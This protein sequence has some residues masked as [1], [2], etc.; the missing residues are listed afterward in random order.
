MKLKKI[1]IFCLWSFCTVCA[2]LV[3]A[4]AWSQQRWQFNEAQQALT[5]GDVATFNKIVE[6]LQDYPIVHYLRYFYLKSYLETV[7]NADVQAFLDKYS[8]SPAGLALRVV[9]LKKL[10]EKQDWPAFLAAY[11]PQKDVSLQCYQ[12]QARIATEQE[13]TGVVE[14][15]KELWLVGKDQP[16]VCDPVFAYFYEQA[17]L[18]DDLRWQR[19]R[20]AMQEGNLKLASQLSKDLPE[21]DKQKVVYW[22]ELYQKP[23]KVL[24]KFDYADT[25][26]TREMLLQGVKRL[27]REEADTAHTYWEHYQKKYAVTA[28]ESAQLSRYI[29]VQGAKQNLPE[30]STWLAAIPNDL[31]DVDVRQARLQAALA[32]PDWPAVLNLVAL[33]PTAEQNNPQW[34]Y[35][36]ARALAETQQMDKAKE[37]FTALAKL[38]D[39]YGFLAAER[40]QQSY[41]FQAKGSR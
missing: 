39:F 8:D 15:A 4:D 21:V 24:K 35:W 10:G 11:T 26:L 13:L 9:C 7:S 6:T 20:L 41:Q 18:T 29:A 31:A 40:L 3:H 30:A 28:E 5:K 17:P 23:D 14:A 25:P 22:Q 37:M 19:I 32:K 33:L 36:Q 34:Q 16:S 12:L 2:P 27:A 38:R 1:S